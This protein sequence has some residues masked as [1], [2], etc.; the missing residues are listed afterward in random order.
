MINEQEHENV[1]N[2]D[3]M[4]QYVP[5]MCHLISDLVKLFCYYCL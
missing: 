5:L 4:I 3:D 2:N 1:L